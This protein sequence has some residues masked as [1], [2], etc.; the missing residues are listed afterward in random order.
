MKINFLPLDYK[1]FD[2]EKKN[3]M[4][5][6]GRNEKGKKICVI[7]SCKNYLW[8][9]LGEGLSDRKIKELVEKIKK[10]K[11]K[12][13]GRESKIESVEILEKNFLE[14]KVK[15]LKISVTNY[16]DLHD[17]ADNLGFEEI[18]KRRGYD[19]GYTTHYI[20]EKELEP[21]RWYEISGEL[22]N[23]SEKF[24]GVDSVLDVDFCIALESFREIKEKKY[25]PKALAFDKIGRAHV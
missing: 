17:V 16:K 2:F 24:G 25:S 11:I 14:K 12:K 1:S 6:Y 9:I 20:I 15:A 22:L 18:I 5:I 19:L 13:V 21:L 4:R 7:D 23:N 3:Y 10:I 8:A